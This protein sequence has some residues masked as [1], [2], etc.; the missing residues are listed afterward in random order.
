MKPSITSTSSEGGSIIFSIEGRLPAST[1]KENPKYPWSPWQVEF[2][3]KALERAA[4]NVLLAQANL[5]HV[6]TVVESRAKERSERK[7]ATKAERLRAE[8]AKVEQP[9]ALPAAIL[10]QEA[11]ECSEAQSTAHSP[12]SGCEPSGRARSAGGRR[13]RG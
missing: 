10:P 6:R 2:Q 4:E 1:V 11:T 3:A 7:A 5:E 12:A 8:L 13:R 9:G